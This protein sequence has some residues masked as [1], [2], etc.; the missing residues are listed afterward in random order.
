[1]CACVCARVCVCVRACVRVCVFVSISQAWEPK[2]VCMCVCVRARVCG[3]GYGWVGV[4]SVPDGGGA[5]HNTQLAT[6]Y[7]CHRECQGHPCH[8]R[9][10]A[11]HRSLK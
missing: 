3:C 10:M 4:Y 2:F 8:M 7:K 6:G 11:G 5:V 9:R 1:M